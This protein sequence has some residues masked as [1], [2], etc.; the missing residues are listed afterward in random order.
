MAIIAALESASIT[1]MKKTWESIDSSYLKVFQDL[2]LTMSAE[3]SYK[4]FRTLLKTESP[5]AIPYIGVYLG[6]LTFIEDGNPDMVVSNE[7]KLELINLLKMKMLSKVIEEIR[8]Y[9]NDAYNFETVAKIQ[10]ILEQEEDVQLTQQ[11]L[12]ELSLKA[13]PRPVK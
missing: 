6:D 10:K 3:G 4:N 8:M 9:Q 7:S 5:P 13:E 11:E 12:F 1:R 2:K